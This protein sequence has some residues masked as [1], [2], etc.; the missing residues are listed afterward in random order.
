MK[1]EKIELSSFGMYP[2]LHLNSSV[3]Y[4]LV[5]RKLIQ[6]YI[7]N[8]YFLKHLHILFYLNNTKFK[9][10]NKNLWE[11]TKNSKNQIIDLNGYRKYI[12]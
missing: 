12:V 1:L 8:F 4:Y 5:A 11:R 10:S 9:R 6:L 7:N 2:L 3:K